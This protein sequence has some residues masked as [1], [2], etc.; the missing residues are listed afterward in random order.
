MGEVNLPDGDTATLL[1]FRHELLQTV[2][3]RQVL[4]KRRILLHRKAGESLERL[5]GPSTSQIAGKLARHFTKAASPRVRFDAH[6]L[7]R[8]QHAGFMP[9]GRPRKIS[10][11]PFGTA[12]VRK[13]R[14]YCGNGSAM[15]TRRL[16]T[17]P[18]QRLP[19]RPFWT[20][21]WSTTKRRFA[22]AVSWL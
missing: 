10:R 2:L 14:R 4:G 1:E 18:S 12:P 5:Y 11:S 22:F 13:S 7:P 20:P 3:Y 15:F 17:T 16:D 21:I 8:K 19:T 9:T 6:P